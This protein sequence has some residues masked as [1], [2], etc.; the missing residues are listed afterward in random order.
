MSTYLCREC[1]IPCYYEYQTKHGD[2][3]YVCETCKEVYRRDA[4]L[5]APM[6]HAV[7]IEEKEKIL[8]KFNLL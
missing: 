7:D 5:P 8:R 6:I 2:L 1:N 3:Y 4:I